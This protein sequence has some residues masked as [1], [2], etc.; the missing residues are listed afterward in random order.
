VRTPLALLIWLVLLAGTARA[1]TPCAS[2]LTCQDGDFCNGAE[3]CLAGECAPGPPLDCDDG[4]PCTRDVCEAAVG[5]AHIEDAC[6]ASCAG[7]LDGT[8]CADG[9]V[10]T[11]GDACAGE[12]CVPGPSVACDDGDPCTSEHCDAT[13]GCVYAEEATGPPCVATCD[14]VVPDYTP[15]VGDGNMCTLDGCLPSVDLIGNPDICVIGLRSLERQCDDGDVCNGDEFCSPTLGCQHG[16]PLVCDDGLA[17]NGVEG[18]DP[19]LGC[20]PG[21]PEP[22]GT[23][24]DDASECTTGDVCG[25][26]VCAGMPLPPSA[27]DDGDAVTTDVCETGFGCLHC[28]ASQ[29]AQLRVRRGRDGD[30]IKV[31]GE[32]PADAAG[33][34]A[35]AAEPVS[36]LVEA[37][38]TTLFRTTLPAGALTANPAATRFEYRDRKGLLGP[39]RSLRIQIRSRGLKWSAQTGGGSVASSGVTGIDARLVIGDACFTSS[40]PCVAKSSGLV[41]R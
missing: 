13:H 15:C 23:A 34:F 28:R 1:G 24:C 25:G 20:R 33:T 35:A 19:V 18:C 10:C 14:G 17:C 30:A 21:T 2:N 41:C 26:G 9:T 12:A 16:P 5:C 4:D 37:G 40:V 6:P 32:M 3:R 36:L 29:L 31:R 27:C 38:A 22:D 11:R 7:Q 8:R 39:V